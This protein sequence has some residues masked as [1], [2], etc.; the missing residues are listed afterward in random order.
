MKTIATIVG[1]LAVTLYISSYQ[2]KNR[3]TIVAVYSTANLLYVLQYI[4]LGAYTGMAMDTISFVSSILAR[5]RHTPFIQKYYKLI[6]AAMIISMI[7][8][9]IIS[10]ITAGALLY[11]NVFSIV[12]VCAAIIE[13]S[14][15]WCTEE[16]KIRILTLCGSPFWLTYNLASCAYGSAIGNVINICSLLIALFRYRDQNGEA[17]SIT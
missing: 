5:K 10:M 13:T 11:Q 7:A 12:A 9:M 8:A 15:I 2:F 17:N 6:I 4:L 16:R 3:K 1:I 14:A